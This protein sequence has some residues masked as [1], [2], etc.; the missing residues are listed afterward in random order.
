MDDRADEKALLARYATRLT[1]A[2][3]GVDVERLGVLRLATALGLVPAVLVK[4]FKCAGIFAV[5]NLHL[6]ALATSYT[7]RV[8]YA[9]E[10]DLARTFVLLKFFAAKRTRMV[11][12]MPFFT[13]I[14][15]MLSDGFFNF[16]S[17]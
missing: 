13:A 4:S 12:S 2:F 6:I 14:L 17:G 10:R 1:L 8:T 7:F 5:G 11:G 3:C 16:T 15:K 9:D